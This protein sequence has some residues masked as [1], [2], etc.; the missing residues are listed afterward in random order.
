MAGVAAKDGRPTVQD[1]QPG[2]ALLRV[3]ELD[4]ANAD[5]GPVVAALRG[6]PGTTRTL[7]I[8]RAGVRHTVAATVVRFP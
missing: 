2:D 3:G 1:V 7:V 6:E 5:M 8:E 4:T